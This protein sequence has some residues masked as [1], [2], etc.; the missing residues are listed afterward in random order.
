MR[1]VVPI[2]VLAGILIGVVGVLAV[3]VRDTIV[4]S[5]EAAKRAA[6]ALAH[7]DVRD[8]IAEKIVEQVVA[9]QP[10]AMAARPLLKQVVTSVLGRGLSARSTRRQSGT[11]TKQC[12]LAT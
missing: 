7:P 9:A 11:C 3:Y 2:L 4:D 1:V 12:S 5:D 10:D 6:A 8:F